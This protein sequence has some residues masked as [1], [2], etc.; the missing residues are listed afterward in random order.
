MCLQFQVLTASTLEELSAKTATKVPWC[1]WNKERNVCEV[2]FSM[3]RNSYVAL[4]PGQP[5]PSPL[6]AC[7][8]RAYA[9]SSHMHGNAAAACSCIAAVCSASF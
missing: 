9:C 7:L 1:G 8:V 6:G 3:L 5:G 4:M 2:R